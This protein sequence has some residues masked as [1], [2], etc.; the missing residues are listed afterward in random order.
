MG[1]K[2]TNKKKLPKKKVP[3]VYAKGE[4]KSI[5]DF[6]FFDFRPKAVW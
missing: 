3:N 6:F 1:W 4:K 5:N 2:Q